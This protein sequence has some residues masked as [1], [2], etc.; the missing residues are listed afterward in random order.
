MRKDNAHICFMFGVGAGNMVVLP[1]FS[2]IDMMRK[3]E[4][5]KK[6]PKNKMNHR[7]SCG[8]TFSGE[9]GLSLKQEGKFKSLISF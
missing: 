2:I 5:K 4:I 9:W 6:W 3:Q 1:F 7:H 8:F